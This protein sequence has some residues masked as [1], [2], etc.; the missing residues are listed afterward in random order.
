MANLDELVV[1]R[2]E[3]SLELLEADYARTIAAG[4]AP[5]VRNLYFSFVVAR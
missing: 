4:A 1:N 5:S 2:L 3:R